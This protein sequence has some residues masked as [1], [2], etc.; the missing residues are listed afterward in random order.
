MPE[1]KELRPLNQSEQQVLK[2]FLAADE[3]VVWYVRPQHKPLRKEMVGWS[4]ISVAF[5]GFAGFFLLLTL[6]H[7][8]KSHLDWILG[9]FVSLWLLVGLLIPVLTLLNRQRT[10]YAVTQRHAVLVKA[11]WPLPRSVK[12]YPLAA[13]MVVEV[14]ERSG[15]GGDIVLEYENT[16][17]DAAGKR[18]RIGFLYL[19]QLEPVL[20]AL[21]SAAAAFPPRKDVAHSRNLAW[22]DPRSSVQPPQKCWKI[23]SV[24]MMLA[25]AGALYAAMVLAEVPVRYVL[26]A[27]RTVGK[28]VRAERDGDS[29]RPVYEYTVSDGR[30]FRQPVKCTEYF[31]N[32]PVGQE[33][34]LLYFADAPEQAHAFCPATLLALPFFL[35]F[36]GLGFLTGGCLAWKAERRQE[37]AWRE[38]EREER[39]T[40][41]SHDVHR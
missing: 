9:A 13:N 28:I 15:G 4:L 5:G 8:E 2:R 33:T 11:Q 32:N 26:H 31:S 41:D 12:L 38:L 23:L 18:P 17:P 6:G 30:R 16:A 3:R 34:V 35:G 36:W 22:A 29:Y 40:P 19:A 7:Q 27:E 14:V 20:A 24:V 10:F 21:Q 39:K 37:R 25:G 1:S